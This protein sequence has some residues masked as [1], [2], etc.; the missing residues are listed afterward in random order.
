MSD[1]VGEGLIEEYWQFSSN[2]HRVEFAI[3]TRAFV[4]WRASGRRPRRTAPLTEGRHLLH[5]ICQGISSNKWL[6]W[7]LV[8]VA[9]NV[10]YQAA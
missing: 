4:P 9:V 6:L 8:L 3:T 5:K 7:G 2:L 10:S 1:H